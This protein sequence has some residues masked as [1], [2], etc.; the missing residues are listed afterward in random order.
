M[1]QDLNASQAR[2]ESYIAGLSEV[3][4]HADRV[5]PLGDYCNGLLLPLER[6]S[7]EPLA[8][9]VAPERVSAKHQSLLHFVAHSPWS[10]DRV[11]GKVQE[12]VLPSIERSGP[13]K[14]WIVDDT[15]HPKKGKHSVGVARQYCGQL[16]KQ[17]NCQ[18]AVSLSLANEAASLPIAYRLYLPKSW[19][20]DAE[21]RRKAG[22]PED[23]VFKTKPEIALEQI[24]AACEAGV[25]R[26]VVLADAGYGNDTTFRTEVS[27]L[28][29]RYVMGVLGSISLW[30]PGQEPLAPKPKGGRGRPGSRLRRDQEHQ[31]VSAKDLAMSLKP[32]AW[33]TITWR[34]GTNAPLSGRFAAVRVRPAHRD[35]K[36][37]KPRPREWLLIEWPEGEDEPTKFWLSTM[38]S[39]TKR[40]DLVAMTKMRWR[41]ERDYQELKQEVG[42]GHYEGRGWRGFHHHA[43]LCIAAYGFLVSERETIPPSGPRWPARRKAFSFPQDYRPRGAADPSRASRRQL[44]RNAE[45]NHRRPTGPN[46]PAVSMLRQ[47]LEQAR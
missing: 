11:L 13:I 28:G 26:G 32:G 38:P 17:D 44:N 31:P 42:L 8:A 33:K 37:S 23:V 47:R 9:A 36:L 30:G 1:D 35:Q 6:K 22:V 34:D 43:T 15:G 46:T 10:D 14:A 41:I 7:V 5:E 40:A 4:G 27:A 25:A 12:H 45:T 2:L 29:L 16:G 20:H 3:I 39:T 19:A 18:V 24:T 21:R